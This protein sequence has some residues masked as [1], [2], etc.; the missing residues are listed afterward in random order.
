[1]KKTAA[2]SICATVMLAAGTAHADVSPTAKIGYDTGGDTARTV[3][4]TD[5][6]KTIKANEGFFVGAGFAVRNVRSDVRRQRPARHSAR[7]AAEGEPVD[8]A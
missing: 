7:A 3:A 8:R 5:G 4:T 2:V 1:M 6:D